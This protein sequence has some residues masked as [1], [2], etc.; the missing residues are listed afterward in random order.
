MRIL[1]TDQVDL[2]GNEEMDSTGEL[3]MGDLSEINCVVEILKTVTNLMSM[4]FIQIA[5]MFQNDQKSCPS[6]ISFKVVNTLMQKTQIS[7]FLSISHCWA[8][9]QKLQ[10]Y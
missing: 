7:D 10:K 3:L 8:N 2:E 9:T 4:S 1:E 6:E 5:K